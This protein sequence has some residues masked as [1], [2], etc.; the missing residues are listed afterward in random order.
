[1][2]NRIYLRALLIVV[3]GLALYLSSTL[4]R[5]VG[6]G[7]QEPVAGQRPVI[8]AVPAVAKPENFTG[9]MDL[10][11]EVRMMISFGI[12]NQAGL[13]QLTQDL[14]DPS[15]PLYHQWLT[16]EEFGKR[17]GRSEKEFKEAV[18]W[19]KDQG[20]N[21]DRQYSN[22]LAIG[23]TGTVDTVQRVFN[24]QMGRY[25]DPENSR[26]F[27][28]NMGAPVVPSPLQGITI[29][30]QGLNNATA[31][32]KTLRS[33]RLA[34]IK[35]QQDL[36]KKGDGGRVRPDL[37]IPGGGVVIGPSDLALLYDYQPLWSASQEGQGQTVGV[38]IDSDIPPTDMSTY[39][40]DTGLPA[41]TVNRVVFSG[42]TNPGVTDDVDEADEDTQ[43]IS[44]VAPLAQIDLCFVPLGLPSGGISTVESDIVEQD[45]I[46]VVS[47]SF[48]GCET[49][50]WTQSEQNI[51][52]Q[53]VTQGIAFFASAGDE[54]TD[55]DPPDPPTTK[56]VEV[57]AAY[58]GVTGVGGT[59]LTPNFNGSDVVTG[60]ASEVVWNTP[61]GSRV[62]C[63]AGSSEPGGASG[64]GV[65]SIVTIPSYQS[66]A[67]GFA[68]GVPSGSNRYVPDVAAI[69]DPGLNPD[70]PDQVPGC[71]V[72][73]EGTPE[74]GGGT[75]Q[76]SPLL[77]GMMALI[78]QHLGSAQG[79][80]NT[81]FYKL[82]VS[83]YENSGP[84][85]FIDI[86]SGNNSLGS[87]G[88][89]LPS[90][91]TGFSAKT[92]YDPVSGWG[93][94]DVNVIATNYSGGAAA[95]NYIG[96]VDSG[97]CATI[98]GWAANR[99][100]P[101]TPIT[102]EV[103]DGSTLIDTVTA[104]NSR[105]DVAAF[106]GGG[107]D[108]DNGFSFTTPSELLNGAVHTVHVKFANTT[109]DLIGSPFTLSCSSA[110]APNY[111]GYLDSA[112]CTTI[113]G[114]AAD[115]N[116]LTTVINVEVY[117]GSTLI[118]IVPANVAR[119]DVASY[120]GSGS[121]D[122]Y[123]YSFN[124]PDGLKTGAAQTLHVKFSTSTTELTGSPT[125]LT[126]AAATPKYV[127]YVDVA[128]CTQIGGWAADRNRLNVSILVSLYDGSTLLETV[129]ANG[130]RPDVA[131][132]LG[133]NGLHG[134][135]F[136]TPASVMTGS[137]QQIHVKFET[138]TV[139]LTGSPAMLTC[140]SSGSVTEPLDA[141]VTDDRSRRRPKR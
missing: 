36:S 29:N 141:A 102:V 79:S 127:G 58:P 8:G 88:S 2:K 109:T 39:R 73:I 63:T 28:S 59:S 115:R 84:K 27:Y 134:Y 32:H 77:A 85:A 38:V 52:A 31:Y 111:V 20:F 114:W 140:A 103:Y 99:N 57:P 98:A 101:N 82:G 121:Y 37:V 70:S 62:G 47:E 112:T 14:Y 110:T 83:E 12:R 117:S 51:F 45:T 71:L 133:D 61:P 41:A 7:G 55:C 25:L 131:A 11:E 72:V 108:G 5:P 30:L 113:A 95:P 66:S 1:M 92:G 135:S 16:P 3:V 125:T 44:A 4:T 124:T 89:C 74:Y 22:R 78:N 75:S 9:Y 100:S 97:T 116:H 17:F 118:A 123:G 128:N 86:I 15:S 129:V 93:V 53:A 106:L 64:G 48:G 19:L 21:V 122:T 6:A 50:N 132:F 42:F 130:N 126:C 107:A 54:G 67:Q 120:L 119:P 10:N 138:S 137:A 90:G 13:D 65:A 26:S 34:P 40:T 60:R 139:D 23:F 87:L 80:P 35:S 49:T 69:A 24:V 96:Y 81:T 56:G 105:P 76:S 18:N 33:R 68:A 136:A 46:K 104:S 94:P 91:Q 43:S